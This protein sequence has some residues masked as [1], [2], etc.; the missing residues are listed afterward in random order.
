MNE[1]KGLIK[2]DV[3]L[4]WQLYRVRIGV[5]L[6]LTS[7]MGVS[8]CNQNRL[9]YSIRGISIEAFRM[10]PTDIPFLWIWLQIGIIFAIYD[11]LR[12]DLL[13]HSTNIWV[14]LGNKFF[15]WVSKMTVGL[16]MVAVA[17]FVSF[18]IFLFEIKVFA[19]AI[20]I[21]QLTVIAFISILGV[22][23]TYCI[24]SCLCLLMH[25]IIATIIVFIYMLI[26]ILSTSK[27]F[28]VNLFMYIRIENI[29]YTLLYII[30]S[31]LITGITAAFV[32]K[33]ID[34]FLLGD[35]RDE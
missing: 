35:V 5:Y 3:I 31:I 8:A 15:I 14:K 24:Y 9:M 34:F 18:L 16:L 30:A 22:M 11:F 25:E 28:Y 13:K 32:L 6:L 19:M 10:N 21:S 2:R 26:G 23:T 29:V 33:K 17:N 7:I 20:D 1:L 12:S 4:L 27:L